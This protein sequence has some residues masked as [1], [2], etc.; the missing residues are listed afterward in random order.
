MEV[1]ISVIL[2]IICVPIVI[3]IVLAV[4]KKRGYSISWG[5]VFF[6]VLALIGSIMFLALGLFLMRIFPYSM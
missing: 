5:Q 3:T 4:M 2:L 6:P 1:V